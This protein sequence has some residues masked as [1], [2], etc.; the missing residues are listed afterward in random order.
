[1]PSDLVLASASPRRVALL[2][3]LGV[4][5]RQV[6]SAVDEHHDGED[7]AAMAEAVALRKAAAV[8]LL[9]P[10]AVVLGAD[11]VVVAPDGA[12]LGKPVDGPDAVHMLLRLAGHTHT[13]VTGVA[14]AG[15]VEPVTGSELT[16]VRM[17]AFG[18][19]EARRYVRSGEPMDK[20]GAYGI[21]GRG[22]LLVDGIEGCYWNV[23]GLPLKLVYTM[24]RESGRAAE[25]LG[26]TGPG[27]GGQ[28]KG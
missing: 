19:E 18:E 11:T 21:Q 13:V 1:M 24:L 25:W 3:A 4:R 27:E 17:R 8:A 15:A 23:V 20:A 10:D 2:G 9:E 28:E 6:A 14:L 16:R 7:P 5:F 26:P 12:L 22:G